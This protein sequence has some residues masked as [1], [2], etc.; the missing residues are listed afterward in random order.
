LQL[1]IPGRLPNWAA[2]IL[3]S[4]MLFSSNIHVSYPLQAFAT[5]H[6]DQT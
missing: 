3:G 6:D 2:G 1:S 5:T 4:T